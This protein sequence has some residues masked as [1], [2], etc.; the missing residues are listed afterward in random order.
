M[1]Q[2]YIDVYYSTPLPLN[3]ANRQAS[4]QQRQ[5]QQQALL[6]SVLAIAPPHR[7]GLHSTLAIL[8]PRWCPCQIQVLSQKLTGGAPGQGR[9]PNCAFCAPKQLLN[10]SL[11]FFGPKQS[12]NPL[13]T[14]K[15]RATLHVRLDCPMTKSPLVP[16]NSTICTRIGP[17][18]RQKWPE[19]ALFVLNRP[20]TKN[21]LYLGLR[22][23]KPNSEG[24]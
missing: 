22:G 6:L 5:Q 23:A 10:S 15:R 24:T 13:K 20:K 3:L 21:G 12:R 17:K 7:S 2:S 19:C 11:A 16:S 14:D 9:H 18:R 1:C 8:K 4:K